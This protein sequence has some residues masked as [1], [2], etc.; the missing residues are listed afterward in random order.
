LAVKNL[1]LLPNTDV[2]MTRSDEATAFFFA[3]Y[4]AVQEIPHGKVTTYGHIAMLVG[5]RKPVPCLS[6]SHACRMLT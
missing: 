3:V 4:R 6:N 2:A 1:I 5:E